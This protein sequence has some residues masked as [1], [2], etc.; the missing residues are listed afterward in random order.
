MKGYDAARQDR[1]TSDWTVSRLSADAELQGKLPIIRDRFREFGRNE[2]LVENFLRLVENNI[3]G[4]KGF[5]V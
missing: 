2:P 5:V 3:V 1:L 4:D